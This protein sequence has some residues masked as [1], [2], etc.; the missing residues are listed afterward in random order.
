MRVK[1]QQRSYI[2]WL[3]LSGLVIAVS[4]A[5]VI[6]V[7]TET[8]PPH[9]DMARHLWTS[10]QY[11][12]DL[13][14]HQLLPLLQDYHYYP[15]LVYW[16]VLPWYHLFGTG[17]PVAVAS[18]LVFIAILVG[19][20]YALG[21]RLG[22]RAVGLT[23]AILTV[24]YPM[25]VTQF[26]EFQL[27]APLTAMVTLALCLLV[28]SEGFRKPRYT[29]AF[30]AACGLGM[31]TKWTFVVC[32]GLPALVCLA[33]AIAADIRHRRPQRLLVVGVAA[34]IAYTIASPWYVTNIQQFRIDMKAN[35]APQAALEG[36]PLV[37]STA[38]NV[39]YLQNFL[40]QQ[41]FLP[42]VLL[43]VAGL[44]AFVRARPK[45]L[46]Y[47]YP[48]LLII[49][50]CLAFT[51]IANKDPRYTLPV[52]PAIAIISVWWISQLKRRNRIIAGSIIAL[53]SVIMFMTISF[54]TNL[55]PK[56]VAFTDG[57]TLVTVYAQRGYII[58]PPTHEQWHQQEVVQLAAAQPAGQQV[59]WYSGPDTI[60]MNSW[61]W[62]YY[63]QR[64]KVGFAATSNAAGVIAIR[65]TSPQTPPDGF[66]LNRHY[67]LPDG[68]QLWVYTKKAA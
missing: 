47:W 26:K 14:G 16:M 12:N 31:L 2:D 6:W 63:T 54:G 18:N 56:N 53:Y 67:R 43:F 46:E 52:L 28:Y 50:T 34:L 3:L 4:I 17:I 62:N 38:S 41:L 59:V 5:D 25:L 29:L 61:G 57:S 48:L 51:A 37:G 32:I 30:G 60:W 64:Y 7:R 19:S 65:G 68:T 21:R 40:S 35:G 20:V 66:S 9:W 33:Q 39:W 15:P 36:D 55:L 42:N 58:G 22:G 27:D 1:L 45:R 13:H 23:A 8:R 11:L 49:G 10:L 44:V 24:G